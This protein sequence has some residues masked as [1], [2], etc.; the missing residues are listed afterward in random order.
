MEYM[1][2]GP[3]GAEY[4]PAN[5]DMLKL[6]VADGRLSADSQLKNFATGQLLV[7][8]AVPGLFHA[9]PALVPGYPHVPPANAGIGGNSTGN[10][11]FDSIESTGVLWGVIGR[12]A[13]ALALFFVFKGFGLVFAVYA[14]YHAVQLKMHGSKYGVIALIMA[15]ITLIIVGVGRYLKWQG[16]EF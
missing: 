10:G 6:W 2:I 16:I 8:S 9:G 11:F 15:G 7:A 5:V 13:A 3:D 4:G 1:V 14:M 12:C